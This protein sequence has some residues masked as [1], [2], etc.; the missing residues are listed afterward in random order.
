MDFA[1]LWKEKQAE[2]VLVMSPVRLGQYTVS[3]A[4]AFILV[5]SLQEVQYGRAEGVRDNNPL[6]NHGHTIQ[7]IDA[8]AVGEVWSH[9]VGELPCVC[10]ESCTTWV[11]NSWILS[12]L[13]EASRTS[14]HVTTLVCLAGDSKVGSMLQAAVII[15]SSSPWVHCVSMVIMPARRMAVSVVQCSRSVSGG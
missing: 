6:T 13:A 9:V 15:P 10:G 12:S 1:I 5:C 14:F 8:A 7:L 3:A 11:S 2:R 4:L